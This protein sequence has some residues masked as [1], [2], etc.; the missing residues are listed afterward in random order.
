MEFS[1]LLK[2]RRS[3]RAFDGSPVPEDQLT[4]ILEAGQWAPSPLNLQP[5]EF[6]VVTDPSIKTKI[7]RVAEAARQKVVDGGGPGWAGKYSM[8]FIENA[9]VLIVVL[10]QPKKG[11]LGSFF[12]QPQGAMQATAACV[13]NMMLAAADMGLGTV[14]FTFFDPND[15]SKVL[16]VPETLEVAG[17]LPL[18]KPA[19]ELDAPPRKPLKVY[20]NCYGN[21]E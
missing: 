6:I 8:A 13:Q 3:C 9:P 18:G 2:H 4:A 20:K 14:W 15:L 5:W 10:S 21:T 12:N 7:L 16:N 1:D 19:G 11:G 17:V